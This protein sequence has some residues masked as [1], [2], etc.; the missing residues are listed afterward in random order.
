LKLLDLKDRILWN[1][2]KKQTL[3]E[4]GKCL[5]WA[6]NE[7]CYDIE[8]L[9]PIVFNPMFPKKKFD[10]MMQLFKQSDEIL[11]LPPKE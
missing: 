10:L 4:M 11:P 8:L 6:N 2:Q 5:L 7:W 9:K 1:G 3:D